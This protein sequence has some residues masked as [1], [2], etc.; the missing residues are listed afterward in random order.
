MRVE[1]SGPFGPLLVCKEH[2]LGL[3]FGFSQEL[4]EATQRVG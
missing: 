3:K 4:F 1:K 2:W